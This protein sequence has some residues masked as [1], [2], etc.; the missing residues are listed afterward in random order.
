MLCG[1]RL[2]P[3]LVCCSIRRRRRR[4]HRHCCADRRSRSL[5][6]C[7]LDK[8]SCRPAVTHAAAAWARSPAGAAAA[9]AMRCICGPA[10]SWRP[11]CRRSEARG[12][13]GP[14]CTRLAG[15]VRL[16]GRQAAGRE[17]QPGTGRLP[18]CR[19]RR[20]Q[21][22]QPAFRVDGFH[23]W[24]RVSPLDACAKCQLHA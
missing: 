6:R 22:R 18:V 7:C 1:T 23:P 17:A 12:G 4:H 19:L 8:P 21:L 3:R 11:V 13:R 9:S 16:P 5:L 14:Q 2:A 15:L 10:V 24:T 20:Q